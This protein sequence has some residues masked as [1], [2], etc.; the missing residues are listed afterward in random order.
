MSQGSRPERVGD[1]IR[2]ELNAQLTRSVRAPGIQH[3]TLTYV[4]MSKDLKQA[5]VYYTVSQETE[6]HTKREISRALRRARPFLRRRLGERVQLR[7]VPELRFDY[8]N[9]S[10][11]E[12]RVTLLLNKIRNEQSKQ[13]DN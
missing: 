8:D 7:N 2:K 4:R 12:T 1:L 9:S 5:R 3:V 13:P 10:E 11:R 6:G